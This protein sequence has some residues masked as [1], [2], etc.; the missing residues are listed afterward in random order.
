MGG[1]ANVGR[2]GYSWSSAVSGTRGVFLNFNTQLLHPSNGGHRAH[3]FQL[4]CLS[5]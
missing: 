5:E 4:R 2:Y 1:S 3:G